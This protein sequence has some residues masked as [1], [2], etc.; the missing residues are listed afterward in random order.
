MCVKIVLS[1]HILHTSQSSWS[2][3]SA[4]RMYS[5]KDD[6]TVISAL[7]TNEAPLMPRLADRLLLL[8]VVDSVVTA[9]TPRRP[10]RVQCH[11]VHLVRYTWV[12]KDN[13]RC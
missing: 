8:I 9:W 3:S 7:T 5:C 2:R 1:T 12:N 13:Q 6:V 4:Y 10:T 11:F